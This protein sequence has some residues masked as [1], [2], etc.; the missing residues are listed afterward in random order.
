MSLCVCRPKLLS[1]KWST[2]RRNWSVKGRMLK[3]AAAAQSSAGKTWRE[4][5]RGWDGETW[6]RLWFIVSCTALLL[7]TQPHHS[8]IFSFEL[9]GSCLGIDFVFLKIALFTMYVISLQ[10][11]RKLCLKVPQWLEMV[12]ICVVGAV[13]AAE[14]ETSSGETTSA[15]EQ[16]TQPGD[17]A[18][19]NTSQHA[20]G[21][22]RQGT[23]AEE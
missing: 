7:N 19:Q 16:Q 17:P 2:F 22:A 6:T 12:V 10:M 14:R 20:A 9:Q 13:G 5:I 4:N 11:Y 18:G 3:P 15:G 8:F 21:P 23:R 1:R